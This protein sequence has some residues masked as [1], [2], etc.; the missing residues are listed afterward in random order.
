MLEACAKEGTMDESQI[1]TLAL[2]AKCVWHLHEF[3]CKV[4]GYGRLL[5]EHDTWL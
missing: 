2:T 4:E 5:S 3:F 1:N